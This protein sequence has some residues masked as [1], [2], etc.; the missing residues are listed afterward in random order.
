LSRPESPVSQGLILGRHK[1]PSWACCWTRC[2]R[3]TG[4]EVNWTWTDAWA[5]G[6]MGAVASGWSCVDRH[7]HAR[8]YGA[9]P[10]RSWGFGLG[11]VERDGRSAGG[12]R[13]GA[14]DQRKSV[15]SASRKSVVAT[16]GVTVG[17]KIKAVRAAR[18]QEH[19]AQRSG[20]RELWGSRMGSKRPLELAQAVERASRVGTRRAAAC[21]GRACACGGG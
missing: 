9:R 11:V 3:S 8:R 2:D 13:E 14:A 20:S 16:V 6:L 18:K 21:G 5:I 12:D 10:A 4:V 7:R 1:T 17:G 15:L 19:A